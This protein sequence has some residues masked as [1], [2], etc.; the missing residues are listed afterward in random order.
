M[1]TTNKQE[2][3]IISDLRQVIEIKDKG[4]SILREENLR[5]KLQN[6]ELKRKRQWW[7]FWKRL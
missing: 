5:L 3:K 7:L 4:I 6:I 1:K 2:N